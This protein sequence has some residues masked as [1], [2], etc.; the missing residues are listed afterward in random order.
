MLLSPP[1]SRFCWIYAG[2]RSPR[3]QLLRIP[4][5]AYISPEAE[6]YVKR[7]EKAERKTDMA[8]SDMSRKL[9]DLIRQGQEALG[10]KISVEGHGG[11]GETDEGFVDEEW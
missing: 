11:G 1:S 4:S 5:L 3:L 9:A 8:M 2:A 10:T 6:K 7:R